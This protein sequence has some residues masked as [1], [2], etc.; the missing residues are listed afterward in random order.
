MVRWR[1]RRVR[2]MAGGAVPLGD[3]GGTVSGGGLS[4]A[5]PAAAAAALSGAVAQRPVVKLQSIP[6]GAASRVPGIC[7]RFNGAGSKHDGR[8]PWAGLLFPNGRVPWPAS[9]ILQLP[10]APARFTLPQSLLTESPAA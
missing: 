2:G 6:G 7:E 10:H 9:G 5:P 8:A 3:G 4:R 1:R